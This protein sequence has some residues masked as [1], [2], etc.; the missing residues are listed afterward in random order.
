ME[1]KLEDRTN[2]T[3]SH[4]ARGMIR[5]ALIGGNKGR[6]LVAAE[7]IPAD[8]RILEFPYLA[9]PA[10]SE[11]ENPFGTW[12]WTDGGMTYL[13]LGPQT[14]VNHDPNPNCR[15]YLENDNDVLEA[16]RDIEIGEELTLDYSTFC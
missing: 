4:G 16:A 3:P 5:V 11:E 7:Y 12:C 1:T 8:A 14:L 13:V 6:G 9:V 10:V 2:G 15:G